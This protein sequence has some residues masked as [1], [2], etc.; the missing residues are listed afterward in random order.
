MLEMNMTDTPI[1]IPGY[2][3]AENIYQS[4]K[5]L[6]YRARRSADG[7][8]VILKLLR[9][10]YPTFSELVQFRN[11]YAIAKNL[12]LPGIVRPLDLQNYRHSFV[13]VMP[14][15]GYISLHSQMQQW[16]AGDRPLQFLQQFL[17]IAIQMT[18][19]LEGLYHQRVIHKDIKPKN[20]L[21]HPETGHVKLTVFS[22]A[23]LLPREQQEIANPKVIEGTLAYMSPEQTGRMNRGIDYR[24]DFYSLGVTYYE[25]LTGKVPFNAVD[26]MELVHC[27]IAR[28]PTPPM[29]IN[30]TIPQVQDHTHL[31]A[32]T[33]GVLRYTRLR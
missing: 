18:H 21:V 6:V 19:I 28:K 10:E 17:A 5:T 14:N 1:A 25:L 2:Q 7:Q 11:Q 3:I 30:P 26:P 8:P 29:E 24:S 32:P 12:D 13:L 4:Q 27:H 15:E 31:N 9:R 20:I 23:S 33:G 16:H 22:L